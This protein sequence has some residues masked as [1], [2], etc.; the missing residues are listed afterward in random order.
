MFSLMFFFI[1]RKSIPSFFFLSFDFSFFALALVLSRGICS[2]SLSPSHTHTRHTNYV[3]LSLDL[4][5]RDLAVEDPREL[6]VDRRARLEA[7]V[8]DRRQL[9]ELAQQHADLLL[10]LLRLGREVGHR[11]DIPVLHEELHD[12]DVVVAWYVVGFL[13][14]VFFCKV[15]E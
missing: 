15:K 5:H 1:E 13:F 6:G 11:L 9:S 3:K 12:G 8:L 10:G 4:D 14:Q 7:A 2:I